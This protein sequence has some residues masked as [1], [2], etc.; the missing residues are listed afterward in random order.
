MRN[1]LR[2]FAVPLAAITT[3]SAFLVVIGAPALPAGA[4]P[5]QAGGDDTA[6][7]QPGWTWTYAQVFTLNDPGTG[8]FQIDETV[9]YTV[10]GIVSHT[11]YTCPASYQGGVCTSSTP[12]ATAVGTYNTYQVNFHGAVTGGTG[13][14]SGQTLSITNGSSSASGTEWLETS[15]LASVELDQN[16]HIVGT[17]A[18]GLENVTIDFTNDDVYTPAQVNQD[19]RLHSTDQWLENTVVYD[20]GVVNFVATGVSPQSGTSPIDTYGPINATATD[21]AGSATET[22]NGTTAAYPGDS[23]NYNDAA[24]NTSDTRVWSNTFHNLLSDHFLSGIPQGQTCNS[25]Q[26]A[27]CE[28]TTM[29]L[30]AAS[31]PAPSV[32]VSEAI[33]GPTNGLACGGQSVNVSGT[34][35]TG[36]TGAPVAIGVDQS[37]IVPGQ[38]VTTNTTT[39]SGGAYS[40]NVTAPNMVGS[41]RVDLQACKLEYSIVSPK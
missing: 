11:N 21:T 40:A 18:S 34:L 1:P 28:D 22:V 19:F 29:A 27:S 14:A 23:I 10:A 16:Q 5:S 3:L 20:N 36:A 38:V 8:F 32:S 17:A 25:A 31:T 26:T 4:S 37:T 9:T 7:Y 41:S 2:R 35:S 15:N 12:G 24:D 13:N 33:S 6:A 30:T 39:T